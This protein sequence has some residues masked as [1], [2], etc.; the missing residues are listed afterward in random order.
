[1]TD[2]TDVLATLERLMREADDARLELADV[3]LRVPGSMDHWMAEG[4]RI[5]AAN[6]RDNALRN[7]APALLEVAK[8]IKAERA[9]GSKSLAAY[10]Q[11][12]C[13]TDEALRALD[14][15]TL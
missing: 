11:A 7:A 8:R 4:K 14:K 6:L 9:V 13:D 1:M 3:R 15:V 5:A 12:V 10:K 2:K